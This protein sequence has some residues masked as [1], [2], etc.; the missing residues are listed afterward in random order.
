MDDAARRPRTASA[1]RC[2]AVGHAHIDTAWLWPLARN[3]AQVPAHASPTCSTS[4]SAT[5]TS[6]S[7]AASRSSTRGSRRTRPELFDAIA[8][9]R[10]R[11]SL[12]SRPARCGSSRTATCRPASRS[13]GRSS[14]APATGASASAPTRR[15]AHAL[16]ARHVRLPRRRCRRSWRSAGLDTFITNKLSWNERNE[17]PHV[18]RSA[19]AA[20]TA[21]RCSRTCTPGHDYNAPITPDELRR[22]GD[23]RRHACDR[24]P[25]PASGSSRS[26]TATAAAVRP[27]AMIARAH[28][29]ARRRGPARAS[30]LGGVDDFCDRLHAARERRARTA[31]ATSRS[32]TASSTSS[33][34]AAPTRRRPGSSGRTAA[35]RAGLRA[36]E[37]CSARGRADRRR[38]HRA[39]GG[40]SAIARRVED[41]SSCNQFHDILPGTS[42]A[43]VYDDARDAAR[44]RGGAISEELIGSGAASWA[45]QLDTNGLAD[46]V[47]VFNPASA[48]ASGVVAH[49][50]AIHYVADVPAFGVPRRRSGRRRRSRPRPPPSPRSPPG[51]ARSRTVSSTAVS[52]TR[53]GSPGSPA[54]GSD[55]DATAPAAPAAPVSAQPARALRGSA[56]RVGGV[57]HRRRVRREGDARHRRPAERIAVVETGPLRAADRGRRVR[58]ARRA[59]SRQRLRARRR[60]AASRHRDRRSDWHED[61]RLLRGSVS[62]RRPGPTR[63]LRDPVRPPRASHAP[64][65]VVGRG[66][67]FE[68]VRPRVGGPLR[69]R[70]RRRAAQRRQVRPLAATA[71]CGLSLLRSPGFPD[72]DADRGVH[73][74]TYAPDAPRRRLAGRRRR[75]RGGPAQRLPRSRRDPLPPG[76]EDRSAAPGPR[77]LRGRR[78]PTG[79]VLSACKR[80]E[81][82]R[83]PH[84]APRGDP[85]RSGRDRRSTGPCPSRRRAGRSA[86]GGRSPTT[87]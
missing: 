52:T 12:G 71:T 39:D 40:R 2:I 16:P 15:T 68:V 87:A 76:R 29:A 47:A 6:A 78:A 51:G 34:T 4:W 46:P 48:L 83:P 79:V 9:A 21:P 61:H 73:A 81:D 75:S 3:A 64:Q 38:R 18:R 24:G 59:G 11:G 42:I 25:A 80:A 26:A 33:C 5:P 84:R 36:R 44:T 69:A 70:V 50:D 10:A 23:E 67:M 54:S 72:P 37:S 86:R 20:S 43:A 31:A 19:G 65:H 63:D 82:G 32:G 22:G 66:A 28:L 62:R 45:A 77:S 14:T 1:S 30:R 55:R 85:R 60:L 56:A 35:P 8:R 74:F 57:G 58:S 27:T 7:C 49:D 17:F 41:S 13:C 53:A